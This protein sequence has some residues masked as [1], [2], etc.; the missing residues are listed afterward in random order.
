MNRN[1][2][3][4]PAGGTAVIDSVGSCT[5]GYVRRKGWASLSDSTAVETLL[6]WKFLLLCARLCVGNITKNWP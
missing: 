4:V 6:L 1:K 2:A 3:E 5:K